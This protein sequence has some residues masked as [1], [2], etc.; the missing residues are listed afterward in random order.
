VIS[1]VDCA[2]IPARPRWRPFEVDDVVRFLSTDTD[3][4]AIDG[5]VIDADDHGVAAL[6]VI[7]A[8]AG[9]AVA[10]QELAA[11]GDDQGR[12]IIRASRR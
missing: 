10:L 6:D 2:A 3:A 7:E 11:V 8:T 12:L 1:C 4:P 5:R 9:G